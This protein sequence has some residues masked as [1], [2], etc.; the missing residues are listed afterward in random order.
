MLLYNVLLFTYR[1]IDTQHL[2]FL[3]LLSFSAPMVWHFGAQ[4]AAKSA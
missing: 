1:S 4:Y 3:H 2:A